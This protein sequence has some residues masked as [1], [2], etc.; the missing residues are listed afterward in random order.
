[1]NSFQQIFKF[2]SKFVEWRY[3]VRI[4]LKLE[5]C[6]HVSGMVKFNQGLVVRGTTHNV[7][8]QISETT[9][10]KEQF[11]VENNESR[12]QSLSCQIVWNSLK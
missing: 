5:T 9:S 10:F 3:E 1:M 7:S 4:P 8:Y 2:F 12:Q 6:L 11:V